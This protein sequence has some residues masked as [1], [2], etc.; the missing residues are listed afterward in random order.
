M[1]ALCFQHHHIHAV[2]SHFFCIQ[3]QR[4]SDLKR[5]GETLWI[6][7]MVSSAVQKLLGS[8]G[9]KDVLSWFIV[10]VVSLQAAV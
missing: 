4:L 1:A 10:T 2:S 3:K 7:T 6:I 8:H 9:Y 5:M